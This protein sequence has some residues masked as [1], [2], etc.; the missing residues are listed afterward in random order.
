[1]AGIKRILDP[2]MYPHGTEFVVEHLRFSLFAPMVAGLVRAS[3]LSVEMVLL[4]L[5]IASF[6]ATLF[7]A[8]MLAERCY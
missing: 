8:W 6:W 5:H 7:A 1:M 2:A 3:G 4:L